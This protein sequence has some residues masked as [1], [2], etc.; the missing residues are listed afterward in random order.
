MDDLVLNVLEVRDIQRAHRL[1]RCDDDL[2]VSA[3]LLRL[4]AQSPVCRAK[5]PENSGA[6][7][8]LPLTVFAE[9]HSSHVLSC[10]GS[11]PKRLILIPSLPAHNRLVLLPRLP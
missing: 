10:T 5:R 1:D 2:G 3:A 9:T 8:S 6:I 4:P 11:R 7:K